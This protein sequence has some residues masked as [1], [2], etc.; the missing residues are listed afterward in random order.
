MMNGSR[1]QFAIWIFLLLEIMSGSLV[2]SFGIEPS[3]AKTTCASSGTGRG[4]I[5][6]TTT[7]TPNRRDFLAASIVSGTAAALLV[8]GVPPPSAHAAYGA[9][10]NLELPNY[11]EFLLEKNYVADE[12]KFLYKGPDPKVQLQRLLDA[13]KRLGDIPALADDKKW[14]QIQGILTGPLGTLGQT[15]TAIAKD[16]S[17]DVA[18][19]AKRVKT[20]IYQISVAAS[21]KNQAD[22][23]SQAKAAE[24]SL[25]AFVRAAF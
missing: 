20:D 1:Q 18:A 11:I 24:V 4:I 10:S 22:V 17:A 25:D 14:S 7:T 8:V 23:V 2:Q 15:L 16:S 3:Q 12:S 5:A 13:S 21:K 9:S 6:T 19:Q